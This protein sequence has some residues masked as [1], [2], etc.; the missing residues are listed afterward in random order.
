MAVVT[1]ISALETPVGEFWIAT[2]ACDGLKPYHLFYI[3][4][5]PDGPGYPF[6]IPTIKRAVFKP[7]GFWRSD[8]MPDTYLQV[9]KRLE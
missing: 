9:L 8:S 6:E 1:H 5:P 4:L 2:R 7:F 3:P